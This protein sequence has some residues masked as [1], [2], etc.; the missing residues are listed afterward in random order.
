LPLHIL[1]SSP[2]G[3]LNENQ[4]EMIGAARA[5]AD[6]ADEALRFIG[7]VVELDAGR[8]TPRPERIRPRDLLAPVLAAVAPRLE[9]AGAALETELPPLLP[10]LRVDPRLTREALS[11]VLDRLAARAKAGTR[12]RLAVEEAPGGLLI[13]IADASLHPGERFPLAERLLRLQGG[14]LR[15]AT[16]AVEI[17]LRLA[18]GG[19]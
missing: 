7:R 11:L 19:G 16:D 9:R 10:H 17:L 14:E 15:T 5:A 18:V 2:F 4:E 8:V 6:D 13:R 3:E 1:L 12:L